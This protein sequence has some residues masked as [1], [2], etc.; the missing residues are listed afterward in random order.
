MLTDDGELQIR[1]AGA[2]DITNMPGIFIIHNRITLHS[3]QQ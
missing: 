2:E 1:E 3:L